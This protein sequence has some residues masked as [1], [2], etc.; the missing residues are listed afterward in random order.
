MIGSEDHDHTDQCSKCEGVTEYYNIYFGD[1]KFESIQKICTKIKTIFCIKYIR[2][3]TRKIKS[4]KSLNFC[5]GFSVED[6]MRE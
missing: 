5:L 2:D 4:V 3:F 1:S 6:E